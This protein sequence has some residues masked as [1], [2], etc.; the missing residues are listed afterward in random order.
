MQTVYTV[1][2]TSAAGRGTKFLH[3]TLLAGV[4]PTERKNIKIITTYLSKYGSQL[5]APNDTS[6][7]RYIRV[8][9]DVPKNKFQNPEDKQAL[10]QRTFDACIDYEGKYASQCEVEIKINE[11]EDENYMRGRGRGVAA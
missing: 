7:Y 1:Y 4:P 6:S 2:L 3:E 9:I 11:V 10:L 8:V 5:L